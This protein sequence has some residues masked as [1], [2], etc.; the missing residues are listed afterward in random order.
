MRIGTA[1]ARERA[2]RGHIPQVRWAFHS[3]LEGRREKGVTSMRRYF[4]SIAVHNS[5]HNTVA[6]VGAGDLIVNE[7]IEVSNDIGVVE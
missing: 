1:P 4:G 3:R 5:T 7:G 6:G 2:P